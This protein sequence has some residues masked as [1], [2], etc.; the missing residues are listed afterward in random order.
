MATMVFMLIAN[1]LLDIGFFCKESMQ[2]SESKGPLLL[3][4]PPKPDIWVRLVDDNRQNG[5]TRLFEGG[6]RS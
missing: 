6:R 5:E 2:E 1:S 3:T 4:A